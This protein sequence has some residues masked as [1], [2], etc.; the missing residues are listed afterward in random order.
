MK[1]KFLLQKKKKINR[2]SARW[3]KIR[4]KMQLLKLEMKIWMLLP[5]LEK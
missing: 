3:T 1:P 2:P 4:E 5:I